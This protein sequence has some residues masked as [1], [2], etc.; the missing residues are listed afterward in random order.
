MFREAMFNQRVFY[1]DSRFSI[2]TLLT[3]AAILQIVWGLV[4]SASKL[5]ISEIPVE[6]YIAIRWTISGSIFTALVVLQAK[7]FSLFRKESIWVVLLGIGG[8]ALASFGTLYGL[9][10]GGV[11]NFALLGALN[12]VI[13]SLVAVTVLK[14]RPTRQFYFA[15]P[16]CIL[17]IL[18]LVIGKHYVSSW[19]TALSSAVLIIGAAFLEAIIFVYSRKFKAQFSSIQY[20]ALSQVSAAILVWCM[21][22]FYFHQL[23]EIHNLS[24]Q[25]WIAAIF[26]SIV[27]C[28]FC[29]L[30]LYWLLN[31]LDGHRLALFDGLHTLSAT[32]FGILFFND[33]VTAL[34]IAGG[35]LLLTGLIIGNYQKVAIILF[36]LLAPS[37]HAKP[38]APA[39]TPK[40]IGCLVFS[41]LFDASAMVKYGANCEV[42]TAP[43]STFKIAIA[44]IGFRSG[45]LNSSGERFKWDGTRRMREALNKNQDLLSWMK[46]SVVWVSSIIVNRIGPEKVRG[47]LTNLNYGNASVGPSEFWIK[48]PLKISV[49]EQVKYLVRKDESLKSAISL[50]PVESVAGYSVAGKTGSCFLDNKEDQQIG[51]YVGRVKN[52]KKEYAFALRFVD[53]ENYKTEGPGGF[54]AKELFHNWLREQ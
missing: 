38:A 9:K 14:E 15:L 53:H 39:F 19:H 13:T 41:P 48:G 51:W 34:M 10:I 3:I 26:V 17:G 22:I 2:R 8:Y 16:F 33:H 5:V 4:P 37:V 23:A 43:C 28:V 47:E 31:H 45:K 27:A 29:Y 30:I 40:E 24:S 20:L 52:G 50:L 44:E 32:L 35:I 25:A 42:Q 49:E 6:L 1:M 46:D 36:I 54:K 7:W 21:Q 11:S 18:L 12:P